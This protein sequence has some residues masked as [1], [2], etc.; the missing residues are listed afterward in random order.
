MNVIIVLKES[1]YETGEN[2]LYN[3]CLPFNKS[4]ATRQALYISILPFE[5]LSIIDIHLQL[6]GFT[7]SGNL[8]IFLKSLLTIDFIA[9][10]IALIHF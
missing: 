1:F 6:M 10:L 8:T 4:L 2:F 7:P 5:S 9:S 3:Q